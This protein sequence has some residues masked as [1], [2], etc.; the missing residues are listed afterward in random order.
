MGSDRGPG[1]ASRSP[2]KRTSAARARP[3]RQMLPSCFPKTMPGKRV[4]KKQL[5]HRLFLEPSSKCVAI[6]GI[7]TVWAVWRHR[8]HAAPRRSPALRHGPRR[9][10]S[11][12]L[13]QEAE[14]RRCYHG[15][16][17]KHLI[18]ER[19]PPQLAAS[20]ISDA[21][22]LTLALNRPGWPSSAPSEYPSRSAA[23]RLAAWRW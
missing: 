20:F 12:R 14:G 21:R 9:I 4:C 1:H 17:I 16:L 5:R 7:A 2:E 19:P 11:A 22:T 3:P 18:S 15:R 23:A 8:S 13:A 10:R 6:G